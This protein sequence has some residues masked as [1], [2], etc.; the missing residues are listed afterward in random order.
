MLRGVAK[1]VW[2]DLLEVMAHP[3][4]VT[5][6]TAAGRSDV[7]TLAKLLLTCS[8]LYTVLK[9]EPWGCVARRLLDH[10]CDSTR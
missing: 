2:R 1:T 9:G 3:S 7:K 5:D 4:D 10:G 8:D 6:L